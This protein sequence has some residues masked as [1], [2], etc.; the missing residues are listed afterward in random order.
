M[1]ITYEIVKLERVRKPDGRTWRNFTLRATEKDDR[2]DVI[3]TSEVV[4]SSF[5]V[6]DDDRLCV[7]QYAREHR[8]LDVLNEDLR[9][10]R[11][12]QSRT[13]ENITLPDPNVDPSEIAQ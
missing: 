7:I 11:K 5:R 13:V 8:C 6:Y 12:F 2:G 3:G 1:A 9:R 4:G 10:H